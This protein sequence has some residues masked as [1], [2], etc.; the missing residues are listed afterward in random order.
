MSIGA[1][2]DAAENRVGFRMGAG[3]PYFSKIVAYKSLLLGIC[4]AC[5]AAIVF[6]ILANFI[7]S[8]LTPD[9]EL[10]NIVADVLPMVGI[11]QIFMT[12]DWVCWKIMG[13]QGRFT[14][15]TI[16]ITCEA[17]LIGLP[18]AAIFIFVLNYNLEGMVAIILIAYAIG[19]LIMLPMIIEADW[20]NLSREI[21]ARS[22]PSTGSE[23]EV[24]KKQDNGGDLED[25]IEILERNANLRKS[26]YESK[27]TVSEHN[28][29]EQLTTADQDA[30]I[31]LE[32][33]SANLNSQCSSTLDTESSL[34][35][36]SSSNPSLTNLQ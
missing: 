15:T 29:R 17:W 27:L 9:S 28:C 34:E 6:F 26:N 7:P 31:N 4:L 12:V 25:G 33:I 10:Q 11:G 18:G 32:C 3:Q 8:W 1:I 16:I 20:K 5:F 35:E 36:S 19:S 21:V 13:A 22:V 23:I 2:S 30:T 24:N 14:L